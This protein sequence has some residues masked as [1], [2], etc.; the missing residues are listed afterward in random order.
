[1]LWRKMF[2][3]LVENKGAYFACLV[4]IVLGLMVFTAFSTLVQS[5]KYSQESFYQNQNF[6]DGFVQLQS[7]NPND[8]TKLQNIPGIQAIQGR[9]VK[10]VSLWKPEGQENVFLRLL[11][12]DPNNINPIND[13]LLSHG[14]TIRTSELN[15]I[16]LDNQFFAANNLNLN[17][18]IEIIIN[19]KKQKLSIAGVGASP[20]FVYALRSAADIY[21][22]PETFGIAFVPWDTMNNLFPEEKSFNELVF[23]LKPEAS[24]DTVKE[25]LEQKLKP[26]GLKSIIPRK[27]QTSHLLLNMELEAVATM[28]KAMPIMFLA[29]AAAL[30]YITLKRLIEQQRGQIGILKADGYTSQEILQHYLSYA[31]TLGLI[32]G[33]LGSLLGSVLSYP[34]VSLFKTFFNLPGLE[35]Q[36]SFYYLLVGIL[37]SLVFSLIAG[38]QGCK[39]VLALEPAEAM[40]PP[41]PIQGQKVLAERIQFLWKL[42][43]IQAMMA[44]RNLSRNKGRSFFIFLGIMICFAIS[45]FTWSMND[46]MQKMLFD[47]YEKVE[48]YDVKIT[49]TGPADQKPVLRELKSFSG[50]KTVEPIAEIPITLKN[51]WH[52]KD[53]LVLGLPGKSELYN[54]LDNHYNRI[55]P[56]KNGL[57]LSERLA[58]L[59]DAPIGTMITLESPLQ[60]SGKAGDIEVV[61]IIP[62]YIGINAYMEIGAL[63]AF[64][65]QKGLAT[66]F[67]LNIDA[68]RIAPLQ[69]KYMYS[70][71]ISSIEEKDQRL[72]K[73]IEMMATY[74][75]MIYIY[76][77]IGI[78]IGFA[79]IYSSSIITISERQRELASMMVLG[80]S[81]QEVLSVV[82][83][84]Q[85]CLGVPAMLVGIPLSKIMMAGISQAISNDLF[86][87]PTELASS[88]LLLAFIATS[89]SIWIAQR[90]TAKKIKLLNLAAVLGSRE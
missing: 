4:I 80:M 8:V 22:S 63:Q 17:D 25:E 15:N 44:V 35:G 58:D 5:L 41:A 81:P 67:M 42:L 50:V 12:I 29:I 90:T 65:H 45:G 40:R 9:L 54:I 20:E 84:E 33:L 23:T 74:G 27:E 16:Y 3:D 62:Q 72:G 68:K 76:A 51:Q 46:L 69:E 30:L 89:I 39:K 14:K 52:Q 37:L 66:S 87:M 85:W 32:G 47:Q 86:S 75:N 71:T 83:F 2:R 82:T 88:A 10:E 31:L 13:I 49:L 73:L 24:Y 1:M 7:I 64:L 19:G 61:G 78:I 38:Y 60:R 21:P 55:D 59:L 26:H 56:P 53:A 48:T 70:E 28:S 34:L 36:F 18:K 79:I 11:S 77:L 43:S 57:L 6:A